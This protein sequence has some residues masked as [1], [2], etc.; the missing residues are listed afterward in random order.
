MSTPQ[1][2]AV[3]LTDGSSA[4]HTYSLHTF[5]SLAGFDLI[6]FIEI[7]IFDETKL[8]V[9]NNKNP[10]S[11]MIHSSPLP[12]S[13][14]HESNILAGYLLLPHRLVKSLGP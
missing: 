14:V 13:S 6:E 4:K 5:A 12:I 3:A 2:L 8:K 1:K 10:D 11:E 7:R 9:Y